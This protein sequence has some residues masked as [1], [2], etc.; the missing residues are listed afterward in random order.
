[1]QTCVN[2]CCQPTGRG[3]EIFGIWKRLL[4]F[5]CR[6]VCAC[7]HVHVFICA[8]EVKDDLPT[9]NNTVEIK[10]RRVLNRKDCLSLRWLSCCSIP[11]NYFFSLKYRLAWRIKTVIITSVEN[12]ANL[13]ALL[14]WLVASLRLCSHTRFC[15]LQ[16][17]VEVVYSISAVYWDRDQRL[18]MW[19]RQE[20]D[21]TFN[22][23]LISRPG[24]LS[25]GW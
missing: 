17:R 9:E 25:Y 11:R 20:P 5:T 2:R 7:V 8:F 18:M 24:A 14:F 12:C 4:L 13:F 19:I 10:A 15:V 21:I 22:M 3:Y 16:R 1:M 6:H 23:W